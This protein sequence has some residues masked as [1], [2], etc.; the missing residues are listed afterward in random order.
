MAAGTIKTTIWV[1]SAFFAFLILSS[2][3]AD[4]LAQHTV[5]FQQQDP[6]TWVTHLLFNSRGPFEV[7]NGHWVLIDV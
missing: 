3:S 7:F 5:L 4:F 2:V 6:F 1:A